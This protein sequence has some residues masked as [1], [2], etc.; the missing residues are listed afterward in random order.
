M[1]WPG[2]IILVGEKFSG[3]GVAAYALMAAGGDLGT[4]VAP[5]LVGVVADGVASTE[6]ASQISQTLS[7]TTEQIGMRAGLL[8]AS[9]FSALGAI[10]IISIKVY[11]KKKRT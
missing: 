9:V 1:L 6:K 5:Q 10:V 4:S 7:L 3:I 2:S 8:T 11:F